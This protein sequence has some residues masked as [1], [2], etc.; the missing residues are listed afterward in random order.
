MQEAR[1]VW[2]TQPSHVLPGPK[3][4]VHHIVDARHEATPQTAVTS[5]LICD[6]QNWLEVCLLVTHTTC[7]SALQ[8]E[9]DYLSGE[10]LGKQA[11]NINFIIERLPGKLQS[12]SLLCGFAPVIP[13]HVIPWRLLQPPEQ[14]PA[15]VISA[16]TGS[17][18]QPPTLHFR[19]DSLLEDIFFC[20]ESS[21][22]ARVLMSSTSRVFCSVNVC[23]S[24]SIW[25]LFLFNCMAL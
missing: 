8:T 3:A 15:N 17:P 21:K 20:V 6:G 23:F 4:T 9:L 13:D 24:F 7:Q 2:A 12:L 1:L 5:L 19:I 22:F 25:L 11:F 18:V 16:T 10:L 14:R